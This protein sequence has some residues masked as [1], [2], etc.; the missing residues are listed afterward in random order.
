MTSKEIILANVENRPTTRPGMT[1]DRG[2]M[3]DIA[4]GGLGSPEGYT[5][6]RWIDGALEYYDDVWGNLWV[7]MKDGSVKGEIY[8]AVIE[9]WKDLDTYVPPKY[10]IDKCAENLKR[11]FQNSGDKFKMAH[12]GGWIFDN[13]RYLRKLEVYLMDMALY[14]EELT[15]IHS[16]VVDVYEKKI[17]AAGNSGAHGIAIG[18]DMGTQQGLLFSP[19]MWRQYFAEDYKRLFGLAHEYGMKVF[20]HSC[21]QNSQI[22]PDLLQAGVDCFQ[23]DQPAVYDMPLLASLLKEYKA[24][25]WSPVDIQKILPTG[26]RE[27]I[28]EG[29]KEMVRLFKGRLIC[30]N[31]PD[32]PGIGVKE[33][34][35]MW[36]YNE[37]LAHC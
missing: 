16:L 31:Y 13:A 19:D 24:A 5:Q 32:L 14:P 15:R 36:A 25:L 6:K 21:G 2:R 11:D 17:H 7:R 3:N 33:E 35:D 22:L 23:F 27:I 12:I 28:E 4:S 34:W 29:A 20:M 8:K 10:D 30:K 1:F 9:D 18:E 26:D 37:I